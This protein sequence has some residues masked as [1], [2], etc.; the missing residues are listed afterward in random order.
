MNKLLLIYFFGDVTGKMEIVRI[1]P[2]LERRW[3]NM[4]NYHMN[5]SASPYLWGESGNSHWSYVFNKLVR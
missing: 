3:E 1:N 4:L 2:F 5:I